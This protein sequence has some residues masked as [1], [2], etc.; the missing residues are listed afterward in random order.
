VAPRFYGKRGP[1]GKSDSRLGGR[2]RRARLTISRTLSGVTRP[3]LVPQGPGHLGPLFRLFRAALGL[4]CF[5]GSA[6]GFTLSVAGVRSVFWVIVIA[7]SLAAL[8]GVLLFLRAPRMYGVVLL[9]SGAILLGVGL[10]GIQGFIFPGLYL[11]LPV[12]FALVGGVIAI[13]HGQKL[14]QPSLGPRLT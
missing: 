5:E 6:Q 1:R 3:G 7:L 4:G 9:A 8:P 14:R 10:A 11:V 13:S 2:P 12:S